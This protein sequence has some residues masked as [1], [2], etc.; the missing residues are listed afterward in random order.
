MAREAPITSWSLL[1][2]I[3][4]GTIFLEAIDDVILMGGKE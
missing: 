4:T 2:D 3:G 1:S